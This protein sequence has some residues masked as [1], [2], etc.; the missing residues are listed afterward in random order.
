MNKVLKTL[1]F[2]ACLCGFALAE[3]HTH[4]GYTGDEGPAKWGNLDSSFAACKTE[5]L[6]S[7]IN[8]VESKA[9][10][11]KANPNFAI[12]DSYAS[13]ARDIVNNGHTLQV[14][15]DN[16]GALGFNNKSYELVQLHFHTPS[17]N[18]INDKAYPAEVH[19]VHKDTD[20]NLL[21]VGV[22]IQDGEQNGALEALLK[23]TPKKL[24]DTKPLKLKGISLSTLLPSKSAYYTFQGSLTTPPCSGNVTWVV[25]KDTIQASAKQLEQLGAI[26]KQNARPIQPING[27]VVTFVQP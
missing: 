24:N 13:K 22:F 10:K 21:V 9:K 4:W 15:F 1:G 19:L 12:E 2:V 14:G 5:K 11:A 23:A 16:A 17:E 26:L 3:N 8:I 6:Q 20:G 7:P 27:R 18:Q 25:M